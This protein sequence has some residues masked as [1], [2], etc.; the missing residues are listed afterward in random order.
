MKIILINYENTLFEDDFLGTINTLI[1]T[2]INND[3][4]F[5]MNKKKFKDTIIYSCCPVIFSSSLSIILRLIKKPT[6]TT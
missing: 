2:N 5:L 4:N 6:I 3:I 1:E